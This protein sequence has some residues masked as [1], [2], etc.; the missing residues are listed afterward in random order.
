MGSAGIVIASMTLCAVTDWRV[1]DHQAFWAD[2]TAIAMA[3]AVFFSQITIR[4]MSSS[5]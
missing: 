1:W 2:V 4:E 3:I 5:L